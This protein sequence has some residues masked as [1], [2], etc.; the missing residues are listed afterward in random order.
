MK[1]LPPPLPVDNYKPQELRKRKV[2]TISLIKK[3][4]A[5]REEA[6]RHDPPLFWCSFFLPY[7]AEDSLELLTLLPSAA[8]CCY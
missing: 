4:P 5:V 8:E 7:V 6:H 2:P 1:E 3:G